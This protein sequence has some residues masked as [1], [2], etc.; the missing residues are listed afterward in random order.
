MLLLTLESSCDE[1]SAAVVRDGRQV[2]SNVIASQIDVHAL[3]GGVV[4]ELASRKHMEAV[5]V[6]VDDA[7]RQARVALGDIEGIAVTR[8]PGLVGALLVG[9][10]MAKAMAMSLDIPLVGVHHMEGHI[11]APLLEQDVPFPYLALAVSGGHTHL[12]RVDGIGRYRIVGRTLDDAAGEAF[13]KVSKLLGLG[14]PGGAV[15]DRLAA[16]GNPKAFD[17]PRPLLKKPNFDFSFSGIKTALLYYAQSQ[18]GPIEGDHLRDVAASF[19]QAVVEVLCKKTLRAA[20]ETG[21]QRIVVAGGVACNKGLR[22][23]MGERSAKEGFQ[24]FFPSP[25]LCADN[26]AMLGVA[27][28][29]YLAGG[30]TSDLDLNARSNWPLDQAGW[31]Q[32]CR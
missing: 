13:D 12:Y 24:V 23:M 7:L 2:L 10:S 1:T 18:K 9:L 6:V 26:A 16:E 11:L 19:Q 21:L 32:P 31:P 28:D 17:F 14:Y 22:R 8:G 20:R 15:I 30:C 29:A 25:G 5:A 27:G 4:P 3:Y